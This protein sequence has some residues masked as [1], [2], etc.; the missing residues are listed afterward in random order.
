MPL[1]DDEKQ[2]V[3]VTIKE[4]ISRV[5]RDLEKKIREDNQAGMYEA[6]I[7]IEKGM[8]VINEKL[9]KRLEKLEQEIASFAK[10][11]NKPEIKK[12]KI[13]G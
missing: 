13:G 8:F 12:S 4:E 5:I 10:E 9:E 2:E 1:R 6:E 3:S 11:A 7:R